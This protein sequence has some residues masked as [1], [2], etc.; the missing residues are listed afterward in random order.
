[1]DT[2]DVIKIVVSSYCEILSEQGKQDISESGDI[3]TSTILIGQG[4]LLDSL[5]LVRVII[6]VEQRL[7]DDF[8]VTISIADERA[9]SQKNSPFR[10]IGTLAQYIS[11]L[12]EEVKDNDK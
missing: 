4:S 8:G 11:K 7:N 1:M 10:T 3:D 6:N 5:S 2:S 12:L 9:M